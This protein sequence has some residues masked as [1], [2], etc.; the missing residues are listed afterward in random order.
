MVSRSYYEELGVSEGATADEIKRAYRR[1][2]RKF[3]PDRNQGDTAA[4][5]RFKAIG[6]AFEVL[7]DPKKRQMYDEFGEQA[8]RFG[9]DAE[10]ANI[11]RTARSAG[12]GRGRGGKG[13]GTSI[14]DFLR[15]FGAPGSGG[16]FGA[17]PFGSE[18]YDGFRAGGPT[19]AEPD[20]GAD[21]GADITIGFEE[22]AR[23]GERTIRLT[24][25]ERCATCRGT[26]ASEGAQACGACG[27]SGE[28]VYR[29]GALQFSGACASCGGSGQ[30]AQACG[31]CSGEGTRSK[32]STLNVKIPPGVNDGQVIRLR[33]Q[34]APGLRGGRD[35]DLRI[36]VRVAAHP[37]FERDG[38]DVSL[39]VPVTV[40]E[41]LV[42]AEIQIP[43]LD[44]TVTL[45]VP[46]GAQNGAKLRLRGRGAGPDGKRG[47]LYA[48]LVVRLPDAKVDPAAATA[49]AE[50]L[51]KLY[52]NDVRGDWTG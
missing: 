49:A 27:G 34:G 9:Y 3:H 42:G 26:G 40:P 12:G 48:R 2:A 43:T 17:G 15:G 32:R 39:D 23:G 41:A 22:A 6:K 11:Y 1:L 21:I 50:T 33:G 16:P 19:T 20:H 30:M 51:R 25:P 52:T 28:T 46:P 14:E 31:A 5:E 29:Q 18:P 24:R 38:R 36:T 8:E 47:D 10:K 35:G 44:G 4:E 45:R 7:S 37:Y 13:G